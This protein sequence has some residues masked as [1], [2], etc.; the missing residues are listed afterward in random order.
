MRQDGVQWLVRVEG[1]G[2]NYER[3]KRERQ[4]EKSQKEKFGLGR[5]TCSDSEFYL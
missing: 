2:R 4:A 1:K 3:K 5:L